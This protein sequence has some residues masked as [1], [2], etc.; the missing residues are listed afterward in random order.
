MPQLTDIVVD[1][2]LANANVLDVYTQTF[3]QTTLWINNG[4]IVGDRPG[5]KFQARKRLDLTGQTIVPGF[6]DAHMHI[7]SSLLT[8]SQLSPLLLSHGVTSAVA[9]PHE[10]ANVAGQA[11]I[12]YLIDDAKQANVDYFFMLPSAVPCAP[13]EHAG[14]KLTAADLAPLYH[15]PMV[16]GLAEVM[17]FPALAHQDPDLMAKIADAHQRKLPVD[18]H[19]A[20][21]NGNQLLPYQHAHIRSD[22]EATTPQELVERLRAGFYVY[23]REGTVERDL[24]NLLPAVNAQNANRIA[25]CT[26]DKTV[27]DLV[28]EGAIDQNIRLAIANGLTP[29]LAYTMASLHAAEGE[30]L[31]DRGALTTGM[32]ADLIILQDVE[33]VTIKRVMKTGQWQSL[34]PK[35][36]TAMPYTLTHLDHRC[37]I[38]DLALKIPERLA[39][40]I[41]VQPNHITTTALTKQVTTD[42]GEFCWDDQLDVVKIAVVERHHHTGHVG[43]GLVSGFQLRRGAFASSVGHDSHNLLVAGTSDDAMMKAIAAITDLDGG[44]VVVNGDQVTTLPLPVGGLMSSLPAQQVNDQLLALHQAFHQIAPTVNFDPFITL[45]FL[46]LPVIPTLKL[47]DQGLYDFTKGAF[48]PVAITPTQN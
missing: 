18:G 27:T 20:G 23:L 34:A 30:Q 6:I 26:D 11:G 17:D 4:F 24:L 1:Y 14:A 38:A 46:S 25:F 8:P 42:R 36:I 2:E 40:V 43:V 21:L 32:V 39:R 7:E 31:A 10:L 44:L 12:T 28:Q 5:L 16:H 47:T 33:H 22:H 19:L 3:R 15:N 29:E 37:Q 9:D 48:V 13:F 45:S 41:G 35:P